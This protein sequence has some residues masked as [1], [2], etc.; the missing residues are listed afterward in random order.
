MNY[1]TFSSLKPGD[2]VKTHFKTRPLRMVLEVSNSKNR[3]WFLTIEQIIRP[4]KTTLF[5]PHQARSHKWTIHKRGSERDL[6]RL[7]KN[8]LNGVTM[9]HH[10]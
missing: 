7:Y 6:P 9:V 10:S 4:S 2:I 5:I 1:K 3:P 8:P